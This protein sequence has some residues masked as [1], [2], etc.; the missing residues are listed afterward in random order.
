MPYRVPSFGQPPES[1]AANPVGTIT[2]PVAHDNRGLFGSVFDLEPRAEERF[3]KNESILGLNVLEETAFQRL[4]FPARQSELTY[5]PEGAVFHRMLGENR[6]A[7][8]LAK[9]R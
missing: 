5:Q 8:T 1:C 3:S 7:R 9:A 4:L 6:F 2:G